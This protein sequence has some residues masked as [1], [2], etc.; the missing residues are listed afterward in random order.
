MP[1]GYDNM[2]FSAPDG[3]VKPSNVYIDSSLASRSFFANQR[4]FSPGV[5][6]VETTRPSKVSLAQKSSAERR[7]VNF[8]DKRSGRHQIAQYK[9]HNG[10]PLR[11]SSSDKGL[12]DWVIERMRQHESR[13]GGN[14]NFNYGIARQPNYIDQK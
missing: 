2:E 10:F 9:N 13:N 5:H 1:H 11:D 6:F 7:G 8:E 3:H 4:E 12:S 14:P